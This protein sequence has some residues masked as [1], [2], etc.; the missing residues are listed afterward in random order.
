MHLQLH[1]CKSITSNAGEEEKK[2][3]EEARNLSIHLTSGD[4][5][6]KKRGF[7]SLFRVSTLVGKYSKKV[8]DAAVKSSFCKDCNLWTKKN[9]EAIDDYNEWYEGQCSTINH[10]DSSG[11]KWKQIAN[12]IT[13]M[14][15]NSEGKHE[16]KYTTY[17]GDSKTFTNIL[18]AEP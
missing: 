4:G 3:N 9:E 7:S 5:T 14:F 8:L 17:I 11:S 13:E 18:E 1:I 10:V 6:W 2:K 15:R 12:A 16:V